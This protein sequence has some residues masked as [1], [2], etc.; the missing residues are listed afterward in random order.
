MMMMVMMIFLKYIMMMIFFKIYD[1]D[2]DYF[3]YC[4]FSGQDMTFTEIKEVNIEFNHD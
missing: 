1:D 4:L 2:D 3:D